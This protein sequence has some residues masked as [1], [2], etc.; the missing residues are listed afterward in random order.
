MP[1]PRAGG[2]RVLLRVP[3]GTLL[4]EYLATVPAHSRGAALAQLAAA[5]LAV[6][7]GGLSSGPA[8]MQACQPESDPDLDAK[9][10]AIQGP[11]A[12]DD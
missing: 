8:E 9:L 12:N 7:R 6:L 10:A 4:H 1:R 11:W 2:V 3:A 5:G